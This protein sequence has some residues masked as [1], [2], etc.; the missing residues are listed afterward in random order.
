MAAPAD[1]ARTTLK[2]VTTMTSNVPDVRLLDSVQR[3]FPAFT[4]TLKES[5]KGMHGIAHAVAALV[6]AL[7][8]AEAASVDVCNV[9]DS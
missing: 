2:A 4:Y 9:E 7:T 6:G 3:R 5:R 8:A 1:D